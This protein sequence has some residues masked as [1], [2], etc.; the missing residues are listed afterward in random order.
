MTPA[1][2]APPADTELCERLLEAGGDRLRRLAARLLGPDADDG[3]QE[4]LATAC[5]SLPSFRGEA[6]LTTWF[7]R[8][9]LRVLCTFRRRRD[10]RGEREVPDAEADA[11]LSPKALLAYSATPLEQLARDERR[12]RVLAALQRLSPPLREVLLL[13]GEGLGYAEIA[14]TLGVPAGTVKSRMHSA[15]V[16]LAERLPDAEDLLP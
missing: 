12:A 16:A 9:A 5:R 1:T 15:M 7:H 4:V 11:L 10:R 8:L 3:V 2:D 6:R 13:R 14:T